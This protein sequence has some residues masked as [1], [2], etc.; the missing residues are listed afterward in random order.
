MHAQVRL[1]ADL[2]D[3]A[4]AA[5]LTVPI[6][7]PRSVKDLVESV[8]V[9]H[10]E[11]ALILVDGRPVGFHRL[12]AGGERVAVF[13]PFRQ[14]DL[15]G[16]ETVAP[17]PV[18]PRFVLDVHLG[19]LTRRLR[20]LGF[21]CWY[22]TDADDAEL[23][24]VAVTEERILLTRDRGLL[25]R[26]EIAHG[27]CPRNDDPELQLLEVVDRYRL[28]PRAAPFSRC[29]RC[30][31]VLQPTTPE[32]VRGE[33]PPRILSEHGTFTRCAG[34]DQVFWP[35]SHRR[36]MGTWVDGLLEDDAS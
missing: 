28:A 15:A 21:D 18:E 25:M 19:T 16:V 11:I 33:V 23:A 1:Y 30:N 7:S 5:E 10:P 27:Y 14:L 34:C 3:L 9:P 24:R 17:P 26:S 2:A 20:T 13:P 4:G 29:V 35:G 36:A 31:G 12:V 8:G 6:G 22:R 32:A